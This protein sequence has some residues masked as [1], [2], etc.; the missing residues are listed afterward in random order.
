MG[1]RHLGRDLAEGHSRASHAHDG[2]AQRCLEEADCESASEEEEPG[3]TYVLVLKRFRLL[4]SGW[5][6]G[7]AT[8]RAWFP[9][10]WPWPPSDQVTSEA[11]RANQAG[12]GPAFGW[13]LEHR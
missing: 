6:G 2:V 7:A 11:P 8:C 1:Q 3:L 5:L 12:A 13:F 4:V 9:W 10:P